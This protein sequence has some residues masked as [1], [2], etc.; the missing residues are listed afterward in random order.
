MQHRRN[1]RVIE[2]V[3]ANAPSLRLLWWWA[4]RVVVGYLGGYTVL[5]MVSIPVSA[6]LQGPSD[7]D[8]VGGFGTSVVNGVFLSV[9]VAPWLALWGATIGFVVWLSMLLAPRTGWLPPTAA[10]VAT[11]GTTLVMVTLSGP[12]KVWPGFALVAV[13]LGLLAAAIT[14]RDVRRLRRRAGSASPVS[15]G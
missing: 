4:L 13:G 2:G 14:V 8:A 15:N 1:S 11:A 12:A 5:L 3:D 10:A 9:V 6:I 7:W